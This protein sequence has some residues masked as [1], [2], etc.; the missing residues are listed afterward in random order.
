MLGAQISDRSWHSWVRI[1]WSSVVLALIALTLGLYEFAPRYRPSDRQLLQN[2]DF[3]RDLAEW[4]TTERVRPDPRRSG[5]VVLESGGDPVGTS[6]RQTVELAGT[7][8]AVIVRAQ[9]AAE[10]IDPEDGRK[11]GAWIILGHLVG[12]GHTSPYW[13]EGAFEPYLTTSSHRWW[14]LEATLAG[15]LDYRR[16]TFEAGVVGAAGTVL[17]IADLAVLEASEHPAFRTGRRALMVAWGLTAVWGSALVFRA[18]GSGRARLAFAILLGTA[19]VG[20]LMPESASPLWASAHEATGH[21]LLFFLLAFTCRLHRP[22]DPFWLS[23]GILAL[24]A[25]AS[26]VVQSFVPGR[27][28]ELH[29][30]LADLGGILAGLVL[31]APALRFYSRILGRDRAR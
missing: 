20:L 16:L 21:V 30:W 10:I 12:S 28:P 1:A 31:F 29:D 9:I 5:T 17:R 2:A 8:A 13:D 6:M 15:P 24:V 25:A 27:G 11:G 4:S 7:P 23:F 14:N 22:Q 18:L 3:R 19:A 26:E